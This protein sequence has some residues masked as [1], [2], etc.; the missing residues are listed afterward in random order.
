MI[1]GRKKKIRIAVVI[2]AILVVIGIAVALIAVNMQNA[3]DQE[4]WGKEVIGLSIESFP[5][6]TEY[7]VGESFDPTGIRV[8]VITNAQSET[9]F[10]DDLSKL[11]FSGF[12]SSVVNE[13]V[14]V[15]V[16]YNGFTATFNVSVMEYESA[17]PMLVSIEVCN[18][19]TEY[20]LFSWTEYGIS[21]YGATIKCTYSDGSVK[22]VPLEYSNIEDTSNIDSVGEH[23][24]T[25]KHREAGIIKETKVIITITQ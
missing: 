4:A 19:K 9:Y 12:D 2:F 10:I 25:I 8:Q 17:E 1:L 16:S 22:E 7:Y 5:N 6:D 11:T 3:K 14:P 20:T 15:T 24:I 23:T 21:N 13:T 18:L